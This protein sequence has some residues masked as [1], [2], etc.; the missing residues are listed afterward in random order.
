VQQHL[1]L[2][3]HCKN[4]KSPQIVIDNGEYVCRQCGRVQGP[5][6]NENT[7]I[8]FLGNDSNGYKR[9]F[10]FNERISRWCCVEPRIAPDIWE[11]IHDE[12]LARDPKDATKPKYPGVGTACN[13]K[14]IGEILRNVKI[15][16]IMAEKHRSRKFKRQPLTKKRFYDKYY[17]KW[18]TIRW[19]LTGDVPIRPSHQLV[20]CVK[21]I[22]LA[23]QTPFEI[24][25]HH[26]S[27][28]G[29]KHCQKYFKCVHN[30]INYDYVIRIG[31]Q[32]AEK[33]HGFAGAYDLFKEEFTLPSKKIVQRKLRPLMTQMVRY[34]GWEMPNKD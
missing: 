3:S 33:K 27:C 28:D 14:L 13:R 10:Y 9:I 25:K 19:K 12:A 20:A 4:C 8:Q 24:Y 17:E 1:K 32:I 22:F 16:P 29:R 23:L 11:L 5:T 15:D 34:N 18:K 31:L 21:N 26:K 2:D 7:S 30:F 6:Y